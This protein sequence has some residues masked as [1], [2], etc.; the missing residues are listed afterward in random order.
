VEKK[1]DAGR[2]ALDALTSEFANHA[3]DYLTGEG[4]GHNT[5]T[6]TTSAPKKKMP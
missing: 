4:E 6:V 5:T 1:T 2:Q 3:H